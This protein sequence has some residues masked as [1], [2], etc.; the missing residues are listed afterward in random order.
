MMIQGAGPKATETI[1]LSTSQGKIKKRGKVKN[2]SHKQL[3]LKQKEVLNKV[4]HVD[5]RIEDLRSLFAEADE[6]QRYLPPPPPRTDLKE[7]VE[8]FRPEVQ[9]PT[10]HISVLI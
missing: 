4:L 3:L 2:W 6:P 9:H 1:P 8:R 5:A 7:H 10:F